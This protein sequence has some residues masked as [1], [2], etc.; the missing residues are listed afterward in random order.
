[1][2]RRPYKSELSKTAWWLKRPR[3]IR[4][5]M[6]E[7][8]AAFIGIYVLVLIAGLFRLSQGEAA[9]KAFLAATEGPAGL[10]F[11]VIA[12]VFAIYHSYTRF[13]VTPKAMPL[14][15]GGKRVPGVFIVATHWLGFVL[16]SAA[17]WLLMGS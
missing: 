6:R 2:S 3:Y 15:F 10:T 4:Y 7:M 12:M 16:V 14:T 5:M 13:Q 1:M 11:A 17:L 9:Y 8:S